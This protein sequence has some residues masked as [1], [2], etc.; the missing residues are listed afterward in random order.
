MVDARFYETAPA[1]AYDAALAIA[2]AAPFRGGGGAISRVGNADDAD[3]VDAAIFIDDKKRATGFDDRGAA[4]ILTTSAIAADAPGAV[5]TLA[6][7][8]IGF[9]RLADA[10][11]KERGFEDTSGGAPSIHPTAR[12]HRSAIVAAGARIG[13]GAEIGPLAAIGPGVEIGPRTRIGPGATVVCAVIG[14]DVLIKAGARIGQA[15]FGFVPGP[16]GLVR[17]PQLGRAVI[18]D[19][20]E[21]GANSCVDRG[22]L[23]D[24]VIEAGAKIDNLVQVAHNVRVGASSVLAAQAGV[25]GSTTIGKG[26]MLGGKAGLADH[27]TVG[28]GA[29]IAAAAGVMH[30]IPAGERWGGTPARPMRQWFRETATLA[31]LAMRGKSDNAD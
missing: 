13:A 18:G 8:R 15:G 9:A 5:A 2:G 4:L 1:L 30:D 24:T 27:L 22:A 12:V 28:D 10:L 21:I 14:A 6:S 29:Q 26:A 7:P 16:D 17:M 11:H 23:G 25:S 20:A 3:L 19:G 31:K